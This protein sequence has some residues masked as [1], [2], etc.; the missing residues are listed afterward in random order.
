MVAFCICIWTANL[1][2]TVDYTLDPIP[3]D[4]GL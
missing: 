3:F 1:K 4:L 2:T